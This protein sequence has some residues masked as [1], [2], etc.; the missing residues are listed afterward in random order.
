MTNPAAYAC[1]VGAGLLIACRS[2]SGSAVD[3]RGVAPP[4]ASDVTFPITC[5]ENELLEITDRI[6]EATGTLIAAEN[7]CRLKIANSRLKGDIVVDA[8]HLATIDVI[9]SVLEARDVVLKAQS[10]NKLRIS[11]KSTLKGGSAA[12]SLGV[13]G[14]F[15]CVD[16]QIEGQHDAIRVDKNG[17][18]ALK[19]CQVLAADHAI[20]SDANLKL[21]ALDSTLRAS[22]E[23]IRPSTNFEFV[24]RGG[25]VQGKQAAIVNPG[26]LSTINLADGARIEAEDTAI[27]VQANL[28]LTMD[29]GFVSAARIG[30]SATAN[31]RVE[32][33][34]KSH[35]HGGSLGL[36]LGLN[37]E[38]SLH[39]SSVDAGTH[40]VC[41]DFNSA[42]TLHDSTVEAKQDALHLAS[43]PRRLKVDRSRI[44]GSQNFGAKA[45]EP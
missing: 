34:A 29:G 21:S 17:R 42:L 37:P 16:G 28:K 31:A 6:H 11:G 23:T 5:R 15:T 36:K 43:K 39:G 13:N 8:S 27:D 26:F 9:D 2:P 33:R 32:M 41:A 30:V 3:E 45:C 4:K 18:I 40:A 14:E 12:I 44:V 25:I 19:R 35:I 38:I 24:A 22:L 20:E 10:T 1:L 7:N